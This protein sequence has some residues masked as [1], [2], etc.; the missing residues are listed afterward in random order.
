ML[1]AALLALLIV[2]SRLN[3]EEERRIDLRVASVK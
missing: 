2:Q 3:A 1:R